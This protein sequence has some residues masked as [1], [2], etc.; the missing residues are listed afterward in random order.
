MA[1]ALFSSLLRAG[2]QGF[3]IQNS[4]NFTKFQVHFV[5]VNLGKFLCKIY[6]FRLEFFAFEGF[7]S[8]S[9]KN[10]LQKGKRVAPIPGGHC[11]RTLTTMELKMPSP[12]ETWSHETTP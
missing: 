7:F 9:T 3:F 10:R 5:I 8:E 4:W 2:S 12:H 1:L 6:Y 11:L